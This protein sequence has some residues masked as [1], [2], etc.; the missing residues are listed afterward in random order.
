MGSTWLPG[1]GNTGHRDASFPP[2]YHSAAHVEAKENDGE[3]D[4]AD[5]EHC[6]QQ[7]KH[8]NPNRKYAPR[9]GRQPRDYAGHQGGR[10]YDHH[11]R[12]QAEL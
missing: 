1:M 4:D 3:C 10:R 6:E 8:L 11:Q 5:E 9:L 7:S 12:F 2:A